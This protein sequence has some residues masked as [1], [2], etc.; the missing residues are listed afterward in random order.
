MNSGFKETVSPPLISSYA[1]IFHRDCAKIQLTK[2][3]IN[4]LNCT[5][6]QKK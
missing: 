4:F 1:F 2:K 5:F 3:G 6:R